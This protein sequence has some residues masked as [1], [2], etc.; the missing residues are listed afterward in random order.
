[1]ININ[2]NGFTLG[3]VTLYSYN[4]QNDEPT[5]GGPGAAI[6]VNPGLRYVA[7]D[8]FGLRFDGIYN[9]PTTVPLRAIYRAEYATQSAEVFDSPNVKNS[10]DADYMLAE[11]GIAWGF[12]GGNFALTPILGFESLGSDDSLYGLQTP[13]A[14]KHAFNGWADQFLVTPKEGLVNTY[15][16]LGFDWNSHAVKALFQYHEYDS[17]SKNIALGENLDLGA[18][19]S[20]QV[21]K[22]FG[23][24][25]TLGTKFSIY[26]QADDPIDVARSAKKDLAKG[27]LWVE[28]NML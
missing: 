17:E 13:Y 7:N 3:K 6:A 15:L 8:T 19:T 12:G 1:L 20:L 2:Y 11:V 14:T 9:L 5:L 21:F 28:Y 24:R 26:D 23:P 18:E 4:L 25:W 10:Y 22:T 27:W 16:S